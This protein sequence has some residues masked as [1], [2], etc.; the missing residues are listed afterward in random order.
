MRNK[1]RLKSLLKRLG[2]IHSK[3][4]NT[5]YYPYPNEEYRSSLSITFTRMNRKT[6]VV[7]TQPMI[8]G[9]YF[10]DT[11]LND[12]IN[13]LNKIPELKSEIREIRLEKLLD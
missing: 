11:Q 10:L 1:R 6:Y 7:T 12:I 4:D 9:G 3:G 2:F 5:W 8:K 13:F